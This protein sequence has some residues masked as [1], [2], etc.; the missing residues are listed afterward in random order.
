MHEP[1]AI[2]FN[3]LWKPLKMFLLCSQIFCWLT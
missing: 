1:L 3:P 2:I